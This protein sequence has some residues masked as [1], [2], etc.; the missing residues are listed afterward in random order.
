MSCDRPT[1][2]LAAAIAATL[3][4]T[5]LVAACGGGGSSS[6]GSAS[7]ANANTGGAGKPSKA[8][9]NGTRAGGGGAKP[10]RATVSD[11]AAQGDFSPKIFGAPTANTNPWLPLRPG[12]QWVREGFVNVGSRRLP[13][14]VVST[15]TDV[16]KRVDGVSTV[17]VIDQDFN[18]G[19]I[20]EQSIDYLANDRNGNVWYLGSYTEAYEGGQFVFANDAWLA[21]VNGATAG[22]LMIADPQ[23]GTPAFTEDT[24]PGG[25]SPTAQVERTGQSQCVPFHCYKDVLL[26]SEGGETKYFAP[27]V[28]QIKTTPPAG[29]GAQEVENLVNL[30]RLS[31][32][33]LAAISDEVLKLDRHSKSTAPTVF[34]NASPAK[35]TL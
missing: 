31:P 35:R 14:R 4:S 33:G 23:A 9:S 24:I 28:G 32:R 34:A 1:R 20:S 2:R 21:G 8:T 11:N 29:G 5:M 22:V 12:T 13:H 27:G 19:Q 16:S 10:H 26:L 17:A 25:E 15:V 7:A 30:T 18:G 3:A 6:T